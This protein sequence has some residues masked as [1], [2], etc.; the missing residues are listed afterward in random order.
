MLL[1]LVGRTTRFIPRTAV[2]MLRAGGE[3]VSPAL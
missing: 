2:G 3:L 1:G